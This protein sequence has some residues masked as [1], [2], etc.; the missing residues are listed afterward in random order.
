VPQIT[1]SSSHW[2][3][4]DSLWPTAHSEERTGGK[5]EPMILAGA[6][7]MTLVLGFAALLFVVLSVKKQ[8]GS[9]KSSNAK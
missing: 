6:I 1:R 4:A 3:E 2:K 5:S 7:G 9:S 8:G